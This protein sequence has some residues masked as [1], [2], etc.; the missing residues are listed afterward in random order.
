M[1]TFISL[2]LWLMTDVHQVEVSVD[3]SVAS[4]EIVL[5]GRSIGVAT[6]PR[7]SIRCDFGEKPRPHELVAVAYGEDGVELGRARQLVNLP[8]PDAEVEIVL[9]GAKPDAPEQLRVITESS[10]RLDPLAVFVNFDGRA[11]LSSGD[12]RFPLPVH[13]RGQVHIIS[14]E[15]HFP[16][17][18]TARSDVTFGG[19]YGSRVATELTAVPVILDRRDRL[20]ADQLQGMFRVRGEPVQVAAVEQPGARVYLV[21]DHGAW[22]SISRTGYSIDRRFNRS[23]REILR[24]NKAVQMASDSARLAPEK[25]RY[26]LVVPNPTRSR[27]VALFP[28]VGPFEIKRWWLSWLATHILSP[29]AALP[30][31]RMGEAGGRWR[32]CGRRRA[33]PRGRSCWCCRGTPSTILTINRRRCGSTCAPSAFPWWCGR[34]RMMERRARGERPQTSLIRARSARPRSA[35]SRSSDGS[36]SC[37]SR[38][39]ICRA[40]SSLTQRSRASAWPA[41]ISDF[42]FRISDF[43]F[44]IHPPCQSKDLWVGDRLPKSG[45]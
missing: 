43:G 30:G 12:G 22:P 40:I 10:E 8:R 17:G 23:R 6:A 5:D 38:V 24:R 45:K 44:S 13:D 11:L 39:V 7:W 34:P 2:F 42:G 19:A 20:D 28:I 33:A 27:G 32:G 29:E 9:E 14:A 4:V 15:A 18:L 35:C 36:G 3:P 1:V 16:G 37:G 41:E 21:R 25:D 31:Q 26:Y